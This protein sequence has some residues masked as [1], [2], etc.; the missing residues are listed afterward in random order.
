M[1]RHGN[2]AVTLV[3]IVVL[4]FA[5]GVAYR[6]LAPASQAKRDRQADRVL[7]ASW[8]QVLDLESLA[9]QVAERDGR[10]RDHVLAQYGAFTY[11]RGRARG[12]TRLPLTRA[13][14]NAMITRLKR[15]EGV[16]LETPSFEEWRAQNAPDHSDEVP[17]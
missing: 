13:S 1:A 5:A 4:A 14:A 8:T 10:D 3:A 9:G 15:A 6:R 17:F 12:M 16:E 11:A 7:P 2:H